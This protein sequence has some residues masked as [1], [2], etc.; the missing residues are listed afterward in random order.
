M[1]GPKGRF[2]KDKGGRK[3]AEEPSITTREALFTQDAR[4]KTGFTGITAMHQH[5]KRTRSSN[6]FFNA[7]RV[8][9]QGSAQNTERGVKGRNEVEKS[10]RQKRLCYFYNGSQKPQTVLS[11]ATKVQG[12]KK[13]GGDGEPCLPE[14][15]GMAGDDGGEGNSAGRNPIRKMSEGWTKGR[16]IVPTR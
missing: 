14:A 15:V 3:T 12:G 2:G 5:E 7:P 9:K 10:N 1:I 4:N 13:V 11:Q 16:S 8:S 6:A